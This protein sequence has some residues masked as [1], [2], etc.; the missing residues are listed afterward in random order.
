MTLETSSGRMSAS[1]KLDQNLPISGL[2]V[3]RPQ[4]RLGALWQRRFIILR[5]ADFLLTPPV[6]LA[7]AEKRFRE[8][9]MRNGYP[10]DIRWILG[11]D[12]FI[13]KSGRHFVRHTNRVRLDAAQEAYRG[14]TVGLDRRIGISLRAY[15]ANETETF[16]S[17]FV[18]ADA[19]DAQ[20][21]LIGTGL[22]MTC[23][24]QMV[25]A[26]VIENGGR[27]LLL[28]LRNRART[29]MLDEL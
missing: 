7:I 6:S 9:L 21:H 10:P 29:R 18:P 11:K 26:Q 13:D 8:F 12:L 28:A 14:Y 16:A 3:I 19:T 23:P 17:V 24:T 5:M 20:Y 4:R 15:C 27:W 22:K 1:G 2:P 25:P